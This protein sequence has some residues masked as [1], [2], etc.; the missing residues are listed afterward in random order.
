MRPFDSAGRLARLS[1]AASPSVIA[2]VMVLQPT[3]T[4]AQAFQ[5][6][7][8]VALG[9]VSISGSGPNDFFTVNAAQNIIN[10]VP[11]DT[12]TGTAP[13]DFLPAGAS[14]SFTGGAA[15]NGA[16]YTVL[17]RIIAAD[18]SRAI[19]LAGTVDSDTAGRIWFY[20]PGGLLLTNSALFDVGGLLLTANDP[21]GA[22]AGQNFL[23]AAGNF[24]LQAAAGSTASI[25]V[26]NGA[27]IGATG[28]YVIAVAPRFAMDG[29]ITVNGS[30]A[31]VAAR[32]VSF[33]LNGGLFDI[34]ANVGSDA[35]GVNQIT[36]SITGPAGLG[37]QADYRRVYLMAMP[38]NDAMT[39]LITGGAQIGFEVA[40]AA[41]VQGN[42]IVLSGG[43]DV[44]G[45][46]GGGSSQY[47]DTPSANSVGT[48]TVIA[49][50][51]AF[52][53]QVTMRSRNTAHV[54]AQAGDVTAAAGLEIIADQQ[55]SA[56]A[57]A[58]N[59]LLVAGNL[60]L[61][62][63]TFF[64]A[65]DGAARQAG[66]AIL[67]VQPGSTVRAQGDL[68]LFANGTGNSAISPAQAGGTGRAGTARID[69]AGTLNAAEIFVDASGSAGA[70]LAGAGGN[71]V[72]GTAEM[73]VS[74]S[75]TVN[76][77]A[78]GLNARG[79][80]GV[81]AGGQVSG[82][83]QGGNARL[84]LQGAGLTMAGDLS[85][86]ADAVYNPRTPTAHLGGGLAAGGFATVDLQNGSQLEA[87]DIRISADAGG[88]G[89]RGNNAFRGGDALLTINDV[90]GL[91]AVRATSGILVT[92]LANATPGQEGVAPNGGAATGGYARLI[93]QGAPLLALESGDL[94]ITAS[95]FGGTG[96]GGTGGNAVGGRAHLDLQ[97]AGTLAAFTVNM[98]ASA[99]GGGGTIGG[100]AI[101]FDNGDGQPPA[102]FLRYGPNGAVDDVGIQIGSTVA[103]KAIARG[104]NGQTG[105]GGEARGGLI[106]SEI[107]SAQFAASGLSMEASAQAGA[108]SVGG[109]AR[110]GRVFQFVFDANANANSVFFDVDATGGNALVSGGRGGDATVGTAVLV[111]RTAEGGP[112]GS[113]LA[114]NMGVVAR[115]RGG[116][117]G[118]GT[119]GGGAGGNALADIPNV[120]GPSV[121]ID[122]SPARS[123]F[124]LA[125]LTIE[126]NARGGAG[127]S[128]TNGSNGGAGGSAGGG[129]ISVGMPS[130][131][132]T[133][134]VNQSVASFGRLSIDG[135]NSGGPGG[136]A[137]GVG[138]AGRG[139]DA[140]GVSATLL[141][142]SGIFN[143]DIARVNAS[144]FGGNAGLGGAGDAGAGNGTGGSAL[145][146]ATPHLTAGLPAQVTIIDSVD[147][148][149]NGAGGISRTVG[150]IGTGGNASIELR[151]HEAPQAVPSNTIGTLTIGGSITLDSS[152]FGGGGSEAGNGGEGR[153]GTSRVFNQLGITTITGS[154]TILAAGEGGPQGDAGTLTGR[155][156]GGLAAVDL[157]GGQMTVIGDMLASADALFGEAVGGNVRLSTTTAGG[158]MLLQGGVLT[159]YAR[160][161]SGDGFDVGTAG[162]ARGGQ[163]DVTVG[164]GSLMRLRQAATLGELLM[165]AEAEVSNVNSFSTSDASGGAVRI[166]SAGQ[167]EMFGGDSFRILT[168]SIAGSGGTLLH[169]GSAGGGGMVITANPGGS[170][171]FNPESQALVIASNDFGGFSTVQG[172]D[173]GGSGLTMR[174]NGGTITVAGRTEIN[175]DGFAGDGAPGGRGG[176]AGVRL[177]MDNGGTLAFGGSL[178]LSL[179]SG[180]ATNFA[181]G[182]RLGSTALATSGGNLTVGGDLRVAL[183]A[184][185]N[186]VA[187]N[188]NLQGGFLNIDMLPTSQF[189][190]AGRF[191]VTANAV[192]QQGGSN[193]QLFG[194]GMQWNHRGSASVQGGFSATAL[195]VYGAGAFGAAEGGS[196]DIAVAQGLL[197]LA[198]LNISLNADGGTGTPGTGA[199][200]TGG[201]GRIATQAGAELR[202]SNEFFIEASGQGANG[203]GGADGGAGRGGRIEVTNAGILRAT[204]PDGAFGLQADGDGGDSQSQQGLPGG[205]GGDAGGGSVVL[206][207]AAGGSLTINA[208][209]GSALNA[210]AS[211]GNG[212]SS[213]N[214]LGGRAEI[215]NAGN[216]SII[217]DLQLDVSG[218]S[219]FGT[220]AADAT[221]GIAQITQSSGFMS[222][223]GDTRID[224]GGNAGATGIG[225]GGALGISV[226]QGTLQFQV[227]SVSLDAD[228]QGADAAGG[229][230][231]VGSGGT[232]S[233]ATSL[234]LSAGARGGFS[235]P[236]TAVTGGIITIDLPAGGRLQ[237]GG[238]LSANASVSTDQADGGF[239]RGGR[240]SLTSAG[241]ISTATSVLLSAEVSH[242]G[243]SQGAFRSNGGGI[244]VDLTGGTMTAIDLLL[245]ASS[246][247]LPSFGN[248][249]ASTAGSVMLAASGGARLSLT[250]RLSV[251]ATNDGGDA[252]GTASGNGGLATG[253]LLR[254]TV[255]G[256]GTSVRAGFGNFTLFNTA[257]DARGGGNG[258]DAVGGLAE[259][260]VGGGG[261]VLFTDSLSMNGEGFGGSANTGS[262]GAGA[263]STLRALVDG[264]TGGTLSLAPAGSASFDGDSFGGP[265]ALSGGASGGSAA[266][267]A[268]EIGSTGNA[269]TV[270]IG[271]LVVSSY[272]RGGNAGTS[273]LASDGGSAQAGSVVVG[274][275]RDFASATPGN[276]TAASVDVFTGGLGGL[277]GTAGGRAGNAD[278]GS[279]RLA[280]NG[281]TGTVAGQVRLQTDVQARDFGLPGTATGG[282]IALVAGDASN[283]SAPGLFTIAGGTEIF[284]RIASSTPGTPYIDGVVRLQAT[285]SGT[286][287]DLQGPFS[288]DRFQGS[289]FSPSP[290]G[291]SG[292][293]A[294]VGARIDFAGDLRFQ[295]P[296]DVALND[297]GTIA[298]T[299]SMTI[300]S[301]GRVVTSFGTPTAGA[302]G[303]V[304]ATGVNI[305]ATRGLDLASNIIAPLDVVLFSGELLRTG[306]LRGGRQIVVAGQD[307]AIGNV[308][309]GARL[310]LDAVN[311]LAAGTIDAGVVDPLAG[312]TASALVRA[313]GAMTIGAVASAL[314]IG[315]VAGGALASGDLVSGR[316]IAILGGGLVATGSIA[317]PTTA[318]VRFDDYAQRLLITVGEGPPSYSALFAA[319]PS[320]LPGAIDIGGSV[321][322][323]LFEAR[324]SSAFR[325]SGTVN[326]AIG[327][328]L[329]AGRFNLA[330]LSTQGFLDLFS[331]DSM[332]LG[333]VTAPGALTIGSNGSITVGNI[334]AGQSLSLSTSQP[335]TSLTTGNVRTA[336]EMRLTS[337]AAL[338]TGGLSAGNRVFLNAGG[339]ITTGSIDAGAVAPQQGA[340]GVVFA[341]SPGLVRTGAI[342]VSGSATLSGVLGVATGNIA[343]PGGIVLLDTGGVTT[344]ALS[345]SPSGFVYIA[346][347]DL[348][349]RITFDQT[350]NPQFAALLA[351]TPVRLVGDIGIGGA[352]STGQFIAAA[353]GGFG[354]QAIT[355]SNVLVDVAGLANLAGNIAASTIAMTSGD[356]AI[357]AGA[358]I[359]SSTQ[360]ITL[361]TDA[362]ATAAVIGGAGAQAAGTYSLSG[363][364]FGTLRASNITVRSAAAPMTVQAVTLPATNPAITLQTDG[365]MRVA[366]AVAMPQAGAGNRLNLVAGTRIEVVQGTGSVRLGSIDAPAGTI[367]LQA[368]RVWVATDSLLGQLAAGQISGSARDTALNA[369]SAPAVPGGSL[370]A[371]SILVSVGNELLVQNSGDATLRAGFTAGSGGI[372]IS[373]LG[374]TA[375]DV[376]MNGR[377]QRADATFA[378]N[379]DTLTLV[380]FDPGTSIVTTNSAVNAC[381]VQGG[382]PLPPPPPPPPPGLDPGVSQPV[383]T[384][385]NNV[386]AL[387]PEEESQREEAQAAAEKLPIVLLQRLIDFSPMF[388]DPDATDPVT[389]G[390]NP[391]LWRDP[392]PTG[393]PAPGGVK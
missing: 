344:G 332:V 383:L 363:A 359:G 219:G 366:G 100:S 235:N 147:L 53:S 262:G 308:S 109:N 203:F 150:G 201:F 370:G 356:I 375:I 176:G 111:M 343:A 174:A 244:S 51:A 105:A 353:T 21:V 333:D 90:D 72:G 89:T 385:V 181:P 202:V 326:S 226:V 382:C 95:A 162:E 125:R 159:L 386:E 85:V 116:V 212:D 24:R 365:A 331:V 58:G 209:F 242:D 232:L 36:G 374:T 241:T 66:D 302:A 41:D 46:A 137:D 357:A 228:G 63:S 177:E 189:T 255:N 141:A 254:M 292:I 135:D 276:F 54:I 15:L 378:T 282:L 321:N 131:P 361:A 312:A 93:A 328:L 251:A 285:G 314:D 60:I 369:A 252:I 258:G 160:A 70:S 172:G 3:I 345:T 42:A 121:S 351:A 364:E 216:L 231:S 341:T 391:A 240:V 122:I 80:G 128:G 388:A 130:G 350:G 47:G 8:T 274:M 136:G 113:F 319:A 154:A 335:G 299:G 168:G 86:L 297:G 260:L 106:A 126:N 298:A 191:D 336:G 268:I 55:A 250:G 158:S 367:S 186:G 208:A 288:A 377:I 148:V 18:P 123:T 2:A 92:A 87:N 329:S 206:A 17:N 119:S 34:T 387:T 290:D 234:N 12:A 355:A 305:N 156:F 217:G 230:I 98:D 261:S 117:G 340:S 214:A 59:S 82:N 307:V 225:S 11:T 67:A 179:V 97:N 103:L 183:D 352:V 223:R 45:V 266:G 9:N 199:I 38:R 167:L 107:R 194:G 25:T 342:N 280:V 161:R 287:L 265:V 187:D 315:L 294:G 195:A 362:S 61:N 372:R 324:T 178:S 30:A 102:V 210:G 91:T 306:N 373:R 65:Q 29:T 76:V 146:L 309:S 50:S 368:P 277:A 381:L 205:R 81:G 163:I 293:V 376:V 78:I 188:R 389:S 96:V 239:A 164:A 269:G 185:Y 165:T 20:A 334:V 197:S 347:H 94:S 264:A 129:V 166:T 295:M 275:G 169:G 279:I 248:G 346:A 112:G 134:A 10:W 190:V 318:R 233:F 271:N 175:L 23:D 182:V 184:V 118:S 104:G 243:I 253:G 227:G 237:T 33:T 311:T 13:I 133:P 384:I 52:T 32:D 155:S 101:A 316:N 132:T 281:A 110:S 220:I 196:V 218:R 5:G 247:G 360:S 238:Q 286:R 303:T 74:A 236:D 73:V 200:A 28:G 301:D 348:L 145:L 300:R 267:A 75:A 371:G 39:L 7:P 278:G 284:S 40:A 193:A 49:E 283:G 259:L 379:N 256:V 245:D 338:T 171:L 291:P 16:N 143:A 149:A 192:A 215:S 325:I 22:A 224:G 289:T 1:L 211:S 320:T 71:G 337:A 35:A 246:Q 322:T 263:A 64:D 19:Q 26:E 152:G 37:A 380:Q 157:D 140:T 144:G 304:T 222:V 4:H 79:A 221:G 57:A 43:Y 390:G 44:R 358:T 249:G 354:A 68:F 349:P 327:T 83:A 272:A 142:R 270:T 296:G 84:L 173:G 124:A 229:F 330:A 99:I 62:A 310:Q 120:D 48:A 127:G 153:G 6:A 108:G 180:G 170:I 27:R 69:V 88:F 151:R 115:A 207:N 198:G 56:G 273:A 393:A 14:A 313:G 317:T 138:V 257:G 323:G 213:G 139:G 31:L 392:V 339:G 77:S 204:L 114:D